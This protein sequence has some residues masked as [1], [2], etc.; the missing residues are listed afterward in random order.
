MGKKGDKKKGLIQKARRL[1]A[2]PTLITASIAPFA[3]MALKYRLDK[4]AEENRRTLDE[5]KRRD[6]AK[7]IEAILNKKGKVDLHN[8]GSGG[9]SAILRRIDKLRTYLGVIKRNNAK[10]VNVGGKSMDTQRIK[11]DIAK[12][13]KR[14]N[15]RR[16]QRMA[17]EAGDVDKVIEFITPAL[18]ARIARFIKDKYGKAKSSV[19]RKIKKAGKD[20]GEGYGEGVASKID[21]NK[22][23]KVVEEAAKKAGEK[24]QQGSINVKDPKRALKIAGLV[25][26]GATLAGAGGAIGIKYGKKATKALGLEEDERTKKRR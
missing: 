9:S 14:Y 26:G 11:M 25:A 15:Q 12:L 24:F 16:E 6:H 10:G 23:N 13:Q 18:N 21:K 2:S 1:N 19:R 5:K 7:R 3:A 4:K 8:F 17:L 22:I 20:F